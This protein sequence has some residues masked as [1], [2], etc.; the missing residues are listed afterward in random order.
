MSEGG[1]P[2]VG[3][4]G[5]GIGG[6]VA[7]QMEYV[8]ST[9]VHT[10]RASHFVGPTQPRPPHFCDSPAT[11]AGSGVG[12]HCEYI[13]VA[14]VHALAPQ[15]AVGPVQ[16]VP[17]HWP[18][19]KAHAGGGAP[20]T[21]GMP[22][23]ARHRADADVARE[24]KS[25]TLTNV[26]IL[27]LPRGTEKK[28]SRAGKTD[29]M[30]ELFDPTGLTPKG[31]DALAARTLAGVR[32][33]VPA[34]ESELWNVLRAEWRHGRVQHGPQMGEAGEFHPRQAADVIAAEL[35]RRGV[36]LQQDGTLTAADLAE[37]LV[38]R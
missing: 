25:S 9:T 37:F 13:A 38:G 5:G 24:P 12:R 21:G 10:V 28:R 20:Y 34:S 29:S 7:T 4:I 1:M 16:P 35:T 19:R 27:C 22:A 26:F 31:L 11:S 3:G 32:R 36:P 14:V 33:G 17:P 6:A 15:H 23:C 30:A 18:N 8:E 2:S